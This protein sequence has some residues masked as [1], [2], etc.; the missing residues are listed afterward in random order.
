MPLIPRESHHLFFTRV[1]NI[2]VF[3]SIYSNYF[4]SSRT[5]THLLSSFN[6]IELEC[7][8]DDSVSY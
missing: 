5:P 1:A 4:S 7:F 2:G 3:N 8:E 6:L